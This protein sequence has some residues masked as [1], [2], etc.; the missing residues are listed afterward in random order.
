[1]ENISKDMDNSNNLNNL[2]FSMEEEKNKTQVVNVSVGK[3]RPDYNNLSEWMKNKDEH[4]YIGRKGVIF[5]NG[6][7]FPL[8]DSIWANPYKINEKQ[9]REEV[10]KLYSKYIQ[11]KLESNNNLV[12]ELLKLRGKKLGCWCKPECCHGDVLVELI[13]KYDKN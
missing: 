11:E 3:I 1:M 13:K 10:L 7:R 9:S 2:N 12:T 5:I 4:V 6:V 8:Y